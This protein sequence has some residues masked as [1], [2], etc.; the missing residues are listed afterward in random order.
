M[1]QR[2]DTNFAALIK[3]GLSE[4][5]AMAL[6]RVERRLHNWYE[7]ECG[8]DAGCI[9]RDEED[10][11]ILRWYNNVTNSWGLYLGKDDET[12]ALRR[13]RFIMSRYPELKFYV[14]TDPRGCALYI[15]RPNDIPFG[16]QPDA[17]YT[18]GVAVF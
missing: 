8:T 4:A 2:K 7:L 11:T 1:P 12:L 3:C 15:L 6:R 14:Q 16:E 9:Q 18:R 10:P 17:Y 13:L 5:D